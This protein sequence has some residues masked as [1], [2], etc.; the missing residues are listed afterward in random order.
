LAKTR[1]E[2]MHVNG[3]LMEAIQQKVGVYDFRLVYQQTKQR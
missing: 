2:C 1:I 3:Q